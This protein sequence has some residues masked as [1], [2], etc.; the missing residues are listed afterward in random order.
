VTPLSP[1]RA[2]LSSWEF[3]QKLVKKLPALEADGVRIIVVGLGSADNARRFSET[4]NFPL[5]LLYAG[6]QMC[7]PLAPG[8]RSPVGWPTLI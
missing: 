5:Q 1:A 8:K 2:D 6:E 3:A 4:L 7:L